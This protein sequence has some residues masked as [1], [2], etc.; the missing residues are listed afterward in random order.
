MA[1]TFLYR[2]S[3]NQT[4]FINGGADFLLERIDGL[5]V[6]PVDTQGESAPYQDGY[7]Y[8]DSLI[9]ARVLDFVCQIR[10]G[11][12]AQKRRQVIQT[13][14]AKLGKGTLT[15]NFNGVVRTLD[16]VVDGLPNM[17]DARPN[18][19]D[20]FQRF[21][22]TLV[23]PNPYYEGPMEQFTLAGFLGGF[24]FPFSFP[25][26]FGTVGSTIVID[27][28]GDTIAPLFIVLNGPL[29]NPTL[30]NATTGEVIT[31]T[32]NLLAGESLEINTA[33]GEKSIVIVDALGN[34]S[35]GFQFVSPASVLFGLQVGPNTLTYTADV[36]PSATAVS[37]MF[38]KRYIGL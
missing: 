7:T 13:L 19:F 6:A 29:T 12:Q 14:N 2:N 15:I 34:R 23:A 33:I 16:V 20:N 36:Q 22:F 1:I 35:N 21:T 30:T 10:G 38:K 9:N 18:R 26:S 8:I 3:R 5:S 27:N 4:L 25:V 24:S 31:L 32:Q 37:V 11:N 17:L 28:D